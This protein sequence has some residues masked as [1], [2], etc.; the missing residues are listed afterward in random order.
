MDI[1]LF[2]LTYIVLSPGPGGD[3][4]YGGG[5]GGVLIN[6]KAPVHQVGGMGEGYGGGGEGGHIGGT[7]GSPG[8]IVIEIKK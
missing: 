5:G 7:H 4:Q 2:A 8:A 1:S 3:F 6:G